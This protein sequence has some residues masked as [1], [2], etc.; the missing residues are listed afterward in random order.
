M[1]LSLY[2]NQWRAAVL[3]DYA[4]I[5]LTLGLLRQVLTFSVRFADVCAATHSKRGIEIIFLANLNLLDIE[6]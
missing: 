3:S 1:Y 2:F 4:Y 6:F 5:F